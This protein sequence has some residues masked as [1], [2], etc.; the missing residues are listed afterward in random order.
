[1]KTILLEG[2]ELSG[3]TTLANLQ[4]NQT[5]SFTYIT[6]NLEEQDVN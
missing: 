5:I 4:E 1:M 6:K 3:K 2:T